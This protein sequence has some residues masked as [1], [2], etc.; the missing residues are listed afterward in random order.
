MP[1]RPAPPADLPA[2]LAEGI[3]KQSDATL[4]E[5]RAWLDRL[6]EYRGAVAADEITV[7]ADE[8]LQRVD[9]TDDGTVVIKK[10][11]CGKPT[12]KCQEG[13]LHGPYKYVRRTGEGLSWDYRG[14]AR[15]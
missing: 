6:L 2:Y 10:V 11:S 13:A 8:A 3:P 14:P 7:E 5:L 1:T 15:A 4:R 12:C 9:E